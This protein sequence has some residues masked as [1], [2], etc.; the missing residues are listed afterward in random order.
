M[1]TITIRPCD[2]QEK[3][4]LFAKNL[5]LVKAMHTVIQ[6]M[7]NEEAYCSWI[8]T[9][10]DMPSEDDFIDIASNTDDMDDV[11]GVF[12]ALIKHYGEDGYFTG[13]T[14]AYG[15]GHEDEEEE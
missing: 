6:A 15:C 2:L 13:D 9:V 4:R 12:T 8:Y 7:N 14:K 11:C 3:Q 10:P 1:E 5:E